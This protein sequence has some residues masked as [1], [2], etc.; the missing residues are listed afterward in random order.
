[1]LFDKALFIQINLL[2]GITEIANV[3]KLWLNHA[4]YDSKT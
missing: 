1:M 2:L 4:L 3:S